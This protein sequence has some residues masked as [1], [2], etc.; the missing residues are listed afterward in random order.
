[1]ADELKTRSIGVRPHQR[2]RS[3]R[4]RLLALALLP[5]I[6][7]LPSLLGLG[8]MLWTRQLDSL[9]NVKI[10][11][12]L[13]IARQY[14]NRIIE[15]G[16]DQLTALAQSAALANSLANGNE[17]HTLLAAKKTALHLDFLFLVDRGKAVLAAAADAKPSANIL[18]SPIIKSSLDGHAATEVEVLS[19]A[20]LNS[21]SQQMASRARIDLVPTSAAAP[22]DRTTEDRGLVIVSAAPVRGP[23]REQFV[24][25]GGTLLNQNLAFIDT[26]NDLVYT[27][28]TL[29]QGSQGTA[30][31]FLDDVRI[32]TNVRL[33]AGARALGTRVSNEVRQAVLGEGRTWLD[34]A[35]V[36]NDWY[37]SAYEPIVDGTGKRV[38]MLYVGFLEKPF[39]EA[40]RSMLMAILAAFM[41]SALVMVPLLLWWA[42]SI[43]FPLERMSRTIERVEQG[44]LGARTGPT[45]RGDEIARVSEHLDSLFTALQDRDTKLRDWANELD[46]R[47]V[48]RTKELVD[49][50]DR[51][52][53]AQRQLVMSEKL[54]AIGEITAGVAHEINNPIAVIQG[55]LDVARE[56]LGVHAEPIKSELTLIEQQVH[57]MNVIVTK[58]LQFAKPGEYAGYTEGLLARSIIDDCIVLVQNQLGR[59]KIKV[60]RSDQG[61]QTVVVNR[62]ELQQVII[63]LIVNAIHAMPDG[64]TLRLVTHDEVRDGIAGV[65]FAVS[66]TGVG[67]APGDVDKIF[68]AFFTT[69]PQRGTG[70]GLS[71]SATLM[72]RYGG[73]ITVSSKVGEGSTF[74]VWLPASSDA[75]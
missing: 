46:R 14:L 11:G 66:D 33:F 25:V 34:R 5:T 52:E 43:F 73:S 22:T 30:T 40:K 29:P 45:G 8:A 64:G 13:T 31:L 51:L 20:D 62:T 19:N 28:S 72:A 24:L 1:M 56:M 60:E 12:D 47:V 68:N 57:R 42:R 17:L 18:D 53:A 21:L 37:I 54:A 3:V 35:F 7:V 26:I 39:D 50:N 69:R 36:V 49:A 67:I 4:L 75:D 59:D 74:T 27:A 9:L 10:N 70:L 48:E 2:R 63:N 61:S 65:S 6:V 23:S 71:I 58:L 55:N 44:D 16:S 41:L 32:S 38:G 15:H